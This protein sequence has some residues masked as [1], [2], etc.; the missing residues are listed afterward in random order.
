MKKYQ[1][2]FL[3]HLINSD[4]IKFGEF[5]LKSGRISPYFV[6]IASAMNSGRKACETANA[7]A[8]EIMDGEVGYN[9][10]YIH[11][12]A[13]KGIPLSV[14]V[15][16]RLWDVYCK[17]KRWGY[18]RK[19]LK[20]YGD[21]AEKELVG[22]IRDGDTILIVDDVITTGRTKIDNWKRVA[23]YKKKLKPKGILVA[24]D[25]QE[26]DESGRPTSEILEQ[27][28]LPVYS[29]LKISDIFEYLFEKPIDGTIYVNEKIKTLFDNYFEK[30]GVSSG[31][32]T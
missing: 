3:L 9:F 14:I 15:S 22:E 31:V 17:D 29:I 20:E 16:S 26:K 28:G 25:R 27:E 21:E 32:G 18:D 7:Y 13:Y 19:E 12:P 4:A 1:E 30:Y 11:G 24:V 5:E 23:S 6:N 8:S 2:N 10:D